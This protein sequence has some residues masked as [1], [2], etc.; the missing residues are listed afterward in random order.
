M[1]REDESR[2][3]FLKGAAAG[4]GVVA[5]AAL[6]PDA[7][8]QTRKADA[9][10]MAHMEP[11]G[12]G[13]GAFFNSEES[14]AIAAFAER[15]MPGAPGKPG[16]TDA[17]VLNYIDLALAGAYS[18]QQEFYRHG[19]IQLDAYC[20]KNYN[21]AFPR[22]APAQQDGVITALESGKAEGFAW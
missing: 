7:L 20:R 6:T 16:A 2:R 12:A 8:A 1:S 18:D 17:G 13:H 22:L 15:L 11:G 9:P 21:A 5:T 3:A 14:A 19:L 4:A 10:A